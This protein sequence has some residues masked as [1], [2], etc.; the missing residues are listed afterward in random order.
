MADELKAP[1]LANA[2][3][4]S[5]MGRIEYFRNMLDAIRTARGT[6]T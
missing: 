4:I 5:K 6:V 1:W 2:D 3:S